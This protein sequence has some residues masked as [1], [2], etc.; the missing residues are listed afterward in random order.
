MLQDMRNAD[1]EALILF[2][3]LGDAPA[4]DLHG[5]DAMSARHELETFLNHHFMQRSQVVKI[6]HGRG[7]LKLRDTIQKLLT[8]HPLVEYFRGS[9]NPHESDAVT[10]AVLAKKIASCGMLLEL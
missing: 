8:N 9:T 7:T 2:A 1:H 5:L 10:Y 3:E 4:L 6:V